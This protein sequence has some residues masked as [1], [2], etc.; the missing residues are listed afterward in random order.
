VAHVVDV[1]SEFVPDLRLNYVE[2]ALMNTLSY[3]VDN[4]RFSQLG[5]EF[6]GSLERGI[7]DTMARLTGTRM[8]DA[9]G[10]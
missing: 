1:L 6:T 10:R 7:G 8:R 5:F 9:A 2:S 3:H 4:T